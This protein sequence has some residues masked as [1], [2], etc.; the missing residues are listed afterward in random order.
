MEMDGAAPA[1]THKTTKGHQP[2]RVEQ[3]GIFSAR[4]SGFVAFASESASLLSAETWAT[5]MTDSSDVEAVHC[6]SSF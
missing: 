6:D 5:G 4:L 1:C 3:E 2:R